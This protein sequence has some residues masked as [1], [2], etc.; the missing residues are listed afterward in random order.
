MKNLTRKLSFQMVLAVLFAAGF[1]GFAAGQNVTLCHNGNTITVSANAVNAHLNHGDVLG[2]C[3]DDCINPALIDPDRVCIALYDP[4]CGCDGNTYSNGCVAT[5]G[6]G[7]TSYTPGA[8]ADRCIGEPQPIFCPTYVDPVCGCNGVTYSNA[9]FAIAA[10]VLSS[11]PGACGSQFKLGEV[12]HSAAIMPNPATNRATVSWT[13][14]TN[15]TTQVVV[16]DLLGKVVVESA[17]IGTIAG[18][19]NTY[20]LDVAQLEAGVYLVQ[21]RNGNTA[22]SQ[23]L[24]VQ[25]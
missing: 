21:V 6:Y 15:G 2:P 23:K 4:V 13:A 5:F 3:G 18:A 10:G 25:H 22:T 24:V 1:Y 19:L 12:A 11:T 8:C 16:L 14:T 9:C 7:V 17:P 20:T